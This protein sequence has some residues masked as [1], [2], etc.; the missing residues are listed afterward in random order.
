MLNKGAPRALSVALGVAFCAVPAIAAKPAANWDGL[1]EVNS[2]KMDVAYLMPGADF[3]AF[4]K[5]MLDKPEVAFRKDWLRDMN[6][7][8]RRRSRRPNA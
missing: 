3:R 8:M 7:G 5:V 6:S 2:P 4:R 1:V